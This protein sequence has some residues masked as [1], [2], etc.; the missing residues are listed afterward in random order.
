MLVTMPHIAIMSVGDTSIDKKN[1]RIILKKDDAPAFLCALVM[2][3]Y[4][5]YV[6]RA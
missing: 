2:R 3:T 6:M 1:R 4:V 5:C